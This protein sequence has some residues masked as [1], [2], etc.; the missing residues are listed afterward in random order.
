MS[1][2]GTG[3]NCI[4]VPTDQK[5]QFGLQLLPTPGVR[6]VNVAAPAAATTPQAAAPGAAKCELMMAVAVPLYST[7]T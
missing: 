2:C 7:L 1:S 5:L 4:R 6:V 3:L